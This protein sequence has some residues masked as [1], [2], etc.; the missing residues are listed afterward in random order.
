MQKYYFVS[1]S[2]KRRGTKGYLQYSTCIDQNPMEYLIEAQKAEL[3]EKY[4]NI[5]SNFKPLVEFIYTNIL[6]ITKEEFEK[7]DGSF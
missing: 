6:E 5:G 1:V 4:K 7:Y 3:R 2:C